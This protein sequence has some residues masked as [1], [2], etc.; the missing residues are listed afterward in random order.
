[1]NQ[2]NLTPR[3]LAIVLAALEYWADNHEDNEPDDRMPED[4]EQ[5]T[6]GEMGQPNSAEVEEL[7][8]RL[9]PFDSGVQPRWRT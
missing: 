3:E 5:A 9:Y 4:L 6:F 2:I 7:C 1:M 8:H